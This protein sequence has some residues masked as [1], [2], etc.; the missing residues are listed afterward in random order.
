MEG[1]VCCCS[2]C[3]IETVWDMS[4]GPNPLCAVCWDSEADVVTPAE[5]KALYREAHK[6]EI[7]ECNRRYREAHKAEIAQRASNYRLAHKAKVQAYARRYYESNG[8]RLREYQCE[9]YLEHREKVV[10]RMREYR[11]S[12]SGSLVAAC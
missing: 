7:S 2:K 10:L 8:F 12:R 1:V 3:G 11:R 6:A 4:L 9:Y 5:R